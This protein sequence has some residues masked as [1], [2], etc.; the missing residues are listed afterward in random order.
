[1]PWARTLVSLA[2]PLPALVFLRHLIQA[3]LVMACGGGYFYSNRSFP[4]FTFWQNVLHLRL[5][6][7][8]K[9]KIVF[10]PQSFGPFASRW[11][12]RPLESL[13]ASERIR[14]VFAREPISL[15]VLSDLL[16]AAA[17]KSKL[18]FCPD[19][20]FYYS[21]GLAA[22]PACI[23][24]QSRPRLALALRDWDFPGWKTRSSKKEKRDDYLDGVLAA[25]QALH[26]Q[27]GACI[28][29]FSQAQGPNLAEDD[30]RMSAFIYDRLRDSIPATDLRSF[31]PPDGAA[32]DAFIRLLGQSDLLI[33][34]RLHA[35]IFAFLAGI[36]AVVIGYQHKSRGVLQSLG[37]ESCFLSIEEMHG[38]SLLHLCEDVLHDAE[39]WRMTISRSLAGM[40]ETIE[41][42]IQSA[43]IDL[44]VRA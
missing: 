32:P 39:A 17:A 1:M 25:C 3:D 41:R 29:I 35:A 16:P 20:A 12:R 27:H 42:T 13:L 38:Q 30:R 9:K 19:M 37:L 6:V 28:S 24:N 4:G 10:F 33:T 23:P 44:G 2:L 34:S 21:P 15:S 31:P 36:P 22:A 7:L 26:R 43:L 18:R 40:R 5:A 8:L 14:H 11:S